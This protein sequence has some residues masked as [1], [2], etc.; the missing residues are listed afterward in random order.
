LILNPYFEQIIILLLGIQHP[1]SGASYSRILR[2]ENYNYGFIA[3]KRSLSSL[4]L[5]ITAG[6]GVNKNISE[7]KGFPKIQIVILKQNG[8]FR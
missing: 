6:S 7:Q 5:L 2:V 1:I 8:I 3:H 4:K